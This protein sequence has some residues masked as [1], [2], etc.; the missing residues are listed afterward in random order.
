M[1]RFSLVRVAAAALSDY[2]GK[3]F[4]VSPNAWNRISEVNKSEGFPNDKRPLRLAIE[5]GGCH[6]YLYKFT[7]DD[8]S[9]F[10]P[11]E[12]VKVKASDVEEAGGGVESSSASPEFVLDKFSLSKLQ[13]AVVDFH[14]ELK[15]SAFVVVGNEL[16]DQSCACAMSFSIKKKKKNGAGSS[17]Q[18]RSPVDRAGARATP[19]SRK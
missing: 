13:N 2:Y 11:S 9:K 4:V 15:G 18:V 7:F 16:V 3:N 1:L 6:G 8:I 17:A 19:I 5:S 12:D 10:D 14:S